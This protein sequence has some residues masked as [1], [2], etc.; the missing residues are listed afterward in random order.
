MPSDIRSFFSG[1]SQANGS[2]KTT[3]KK[4]DDEVFD[5]RPIILGRPLPNA[6][7]S[8]VPSNSDELP[9]VTHG[10]LLSDVG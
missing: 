10:C 8:L 1:A 4:A 3:S 6:D 2:Q 7:F 5:T 9:N